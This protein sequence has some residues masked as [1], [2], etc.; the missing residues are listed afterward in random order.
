MIEHGACAAKRSAECWTPDECFPD[1]YP[2]TD[3]LA[4][5]RQ[6]YRRPRQ[7][8]PKRHGACGETDARG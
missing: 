1:E 2:R 5:R 4:A 6:D 3:A 8:E 7:Q